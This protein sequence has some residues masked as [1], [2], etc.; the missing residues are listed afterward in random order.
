MLIFLGFPCGDCFV[1]LKNEEEVQKAV[2]KNNQELGPNKIQIMPV[3]REQVNAVMNS[4]GDRRNQ[5]RPPPQRDWAP[6]NDFGNAGCVV[7]LSNLCYR[8]T[9]N[10]ILDEFREFDIKPDSIIRRFNDYGQPTGNACINFNSPA[11]ASKACDEYNKV[12][13]LNR[14]V[15]LRRL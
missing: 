3:P 1:E 4:F 8:A 13:I 10:D 11:D 7:M 14:P 2:A 15:W 6:P 12:K 5:N 9:I